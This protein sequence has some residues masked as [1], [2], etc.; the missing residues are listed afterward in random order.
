MR[1]PVPVKPPASPLR[2]LAVPALLVVATC[3]AYTPALH[4]GFLWDD[5]AH[6]TRPELRS[7]DGLRRIWFDLGATQ[8]YYPLVHSA[9]WV[10][11]RLWGDAPF[12][13]HLVNVLLHAAV[14]ALAYFVL[15]K[16]RIPGAALAT[17]IFSLHPV[18][19]ESVAWITELKN[20]LSAVFYLTA[21]WSYLRFDEER[22]SRWY[23]LGLALFVAGLLTK[24]VIATLPGA[25]LVV[26]W[27]Q[28]GTLSWKRDALP[29]LPWFGLGAIAGL[30]TAWVERTL[31]GAEGA[32]FS[33]T[34]VERCLLAGRATNFY[35][36]KLFW[37][38]HLIFI[39]P[40]WEM[41]AGIWW[42][43]LFPLGASALVATLWL[44]RGRWRG[45]L[46]AVLFFGG[47]LFPVLGF[48]NVYPFLF[49]Y[50]A[51]HF[52]YLPSLGVIA[53]VS[54]GL[55]LGLKSLPPARRR[56][57]QGAVVAL[58]GA[59]G[60]LTW[61]QAHMY[62]D[63]ETLYRTTIERNPGA[64]MARVNLG[65]ILAER[66]RAPEAAAQYEEIL[67]RTDRWAGP[68]RDAIA[69]FAR[70]QAQ[71]N[72]A[73]MLAEAGKL[74]DAAS[75]LE[76]AIRA[77][78]AYADAYFN[79]GLVREG[80]QRLDDAE[81]AYR[82]AIKL[83]PRLA[84]PHNNLAIVLYA[85]GDY[86]GAWREVALVRSLGGSPHPDFVRALTAAA[87]PPH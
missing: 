1:R 18:H 4:G 68:P 69:G 45:P 34:A 57:A 82:T 64:W 41:S 11:H 40:R 86:A 72:L 20:T 22:E 51:D 55:A 87:P 37:P 15:R 47:T 7:V 6:V 44:M 60:I 10:E 23:V 33:L 75:R 29:L 52:Q 80:Q 26:F 9:F 3:I 8:Q 2:K 53:L 76:D 81:A 56:A 38:A 54:A 73:T 83:G 13:Y 50:V 5:A 21:A 79:L 66:G 31:I 74:D 14:A 59:L 58:V 49:S 46:A 25:L 36:G 28:R 24:T 78:P 17:A 42:Q 77:N 43:Y 84:E 48:F 35:L 30:F 12:G 27:W 63:I 32:A 85:R 67:R 19:V 65:K 61:R 62:G 70:S 71:N 16:L 39:Y